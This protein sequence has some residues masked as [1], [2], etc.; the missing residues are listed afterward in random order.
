MSRGGRAVEFLRD[1]REGFGKEHGPHG[2][3]AD[4]CQR[5]VA[6]EYD[7]WEALV[8]ANEIGGPP[9]PPSPSTNNPREPE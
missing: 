8:H 9:A 7:E 5:C 4:T 2:W 3:G 1:W 6:D